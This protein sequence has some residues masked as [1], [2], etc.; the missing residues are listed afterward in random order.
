M[1]QRTEKIRMFRSPFLEYFSYTNPL[2][3][4]VFWTPIACYFL[5]LSLTHLNLTY[6]SSFFCFGLFFWTFLEYVLHRFAFHFN[7]KVKWS[8]FIVFVF[9]GIHHDDP[10][11]KQRL[12]FPPVPAAFIG[13]VVYS[14]LQTV[15]QRPYIYP[16]FLGVIIGYLIYDYTHYATHHF[17]MNSRIG[18]LIKRNH[19]RHHYVAP[20]K[21]FGVSSPLW[22]YIFRTKDHK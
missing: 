7:A 21:N 11:D 8:K 10:N 16:F 20:N 18:T 1:K 12:V 19:M 22:D 2:A 3:P 6:L 17:K 4:L 9:H 13:V 5:W 15:L 14:L